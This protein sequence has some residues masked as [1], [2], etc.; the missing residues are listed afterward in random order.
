VPNSL[1]YQIRRDYRQR[2]LSVGL[3]QPGIFRTQH[4]QE[5]S[6]RRLDRNHS[7]IDIQQRSL[8]TAPQ[9]SADNDRQFQIDWSIH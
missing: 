4:H 2:P 3:F 1:S 5:M 8:D 7:L 6:F 9:D